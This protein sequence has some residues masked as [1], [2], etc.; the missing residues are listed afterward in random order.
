[1]R[2]DPLELVFDP[3]AYSY[4]AGRPSFYFDP[5]GLA[6]VTNRS[7]RAIVIKTEGG[8]NKTRMLKPGE[9]GD[10]DGFF[11]GAADS[12]N[13]FCDAG[14]ADIVYK[15][16]TSTDVIITGGCGQECLSW[17]TADLT[18]F[19]ANTLDPRRVLG[20]GAGWKG[21]NWFKDH[22]DWRPRTQ[23]RPKNCCKGP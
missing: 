20:R 2:P 19:L 18:S 14:D 1:M 15:I 7:C 12:C 6:K 22:A 11:N 16:N 8:D 9:S 4:A 17:E 21:P 13:L 10:A 23:T 5:L 3:H